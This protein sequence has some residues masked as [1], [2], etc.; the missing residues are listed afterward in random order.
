MNSKMGRTL[1]DNASSQY[2]CALYNS[3]ARRLKPGCSK[4]CRQKLLLESNV[5]GVEK[6]EL[7]L[8]KSYIKAID[9]QLEMVSPLVEE[10]RFQHSVT[11]LLGLL[12]GVTCSLVML[13]TYLV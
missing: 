11:P 12:F 2:D 1:K 3:F 4:K 8:L 5:N 6:D 10:L 13:L 9:E 7:P